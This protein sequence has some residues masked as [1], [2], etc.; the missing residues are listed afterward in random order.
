[1]AIGFDAAVGFDSALVG[2]DG[3]DLSQYS[4]GDLRVELFITSG[5]G[6]TWG[7]V[8][9]RVLLEDGVTLARGRAG[10]ATTCTASSAQLVLDNS[11]GT[12]SPRNT[13]STLYGLIGR[14]TPIRV[15]LGNPCLGAAAAQGA[16]GTNITIPQVSTLYGPVGVAA[17]AVA[18]PAGNITNPAGYTGGGENDSTLFTI[19]RSYTTDSGVVPAATA[20]H[21]V[22]LTA[23]AGAQVAIPNG[24]LVSSYGT[25]ASA[26]VVIPSIDYGPAEA[27]TVAVAFC[28]WTAD[29]DNRMAPPRFD[30][31]RSQN[32]IYLVADSGPSSGPRIMAWAWWHKNDT[33][34]NVGLVGLD[35]AGDG[36]TGG[37]ISVSFW[38]GAD[39][40]SPRFTGEIAEWPVAW[41]K[42]GDW[43]VTPIVAGGALRRAGQNQ[44]ITSS[45]YKALT[46]T[47][48]IG[49][50][51][52]L[53]DQP[54]S[55]I[56]AAAI[57][58]V[59]M[60]PVN[61]VV[62]ASESALVGSLPTPDF[63]GGGA[64]SDGLPD[65]FGTDFGA[66][67]YVGVPA[68]GTAAG[69]NLLSLLTGSAG[70]TIS[71][72]WIEY[73]DT[74]NV[75]VKYIDATGSHTPAVVNVTSVFP[76]GMNGRQVSLYATLAQNG[77]GV[78]WAI[79]ATNVT[80][81]EEH[82][83]VTQTGTIALNNVTTLASVSVGVEGGGVTTIGTNSLTIGHV[84]TTTGTVSVNKTQVERAV[85][86]W[87]QLQMS[88]AV[89]NVARD[90]GLKIGMGNLDT[91]DTVKSGPVSPASVTDN[92]TAMERASQAFMSDAAG[93]VGIEWV[94]LSSIENRTAKFTLDYNARILTGDL[95]PVD[96]D[97]LTLNDMTVVSTAGPQSRSVVTT[98]AL[99]VPTVGR[100]AQSEPLPVYLLQGAT[101]LAN[102]L[103]TQG[104]YDAARWPE[105]TIE[106]CRDTV[107][108]DWR[109]VSIGDTFTLTNLPALTG[110]TSVNL[111]ITGFQEEFDAAT[112]KLTLV[113]R[114]AASYDVLVWDVGDFDE[115]NWG[116]A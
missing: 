35:G 86:G 41:N 15:G 97:A 69:T 47:S 20:T 75:T 60:R 11:D 50:Y 8:T 105:I 42:Q 10:E 57:G 29:P 31:Q 113:T 55:A 91:W 63:T 32:E 53:E 7:D 74:N 62:N 1:M 108:I 14:N 9:S 27:G 89:R 38:S 112:W 101:D 30:T 65:V 16:G 109:E 93:F 23:A 49:N 76:A 13:A 64:V 84:Y 58:G 106:T 21:S 85:R 98:G 26:G 25:T 77:T 95:G 104:T 59:P 4:P 82:Q 72:F 45:A 71:V 92:L 115:H 66:G 22:T 78:D 19:R 28:V 33:T 68:A 90:G 99:G 110:P 56:F 39:R 46:N 54:G 36:V 116:I 100:Y 114:L 70:A 2:F 81:T 94:S 18:L 61:T 17:V 52:P 5:G 96:D 24:T 6:K 80:P 40:Y 83:G 3:A 102:W 34:N 48:Q 43:I 79:Y 67:C 44:D 51:W 12:Y 73:T 111:V 103:T 87:A 107:P 37:A 88:T